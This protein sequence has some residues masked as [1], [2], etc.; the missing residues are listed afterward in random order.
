MFEILRLLC[1]SSKYVGIQQ[2]FKT[3]LG[4][5]YSSGEAGGGPGGLSLKRKNSYSV[6]LEPGFKFS[7]R[8][9]AY[10]KVGY[11]GSTLH[12]DQDSGALESSLD[13]VDYG[14]GLRTLVDKH[15]YLQAEL[16]QVFFNSSGFG[17]Q[18]GSLRTSGTLGLFGIGY[19]F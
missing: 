13:G 3:S 17:G 19:Q 8:T 6:Y 1:P 5:I 7:E 2:K 11:V 14:L 18:N 4:R 15:T 12:E 16:H 9:L 10:F